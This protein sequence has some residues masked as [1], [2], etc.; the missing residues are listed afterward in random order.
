M[1]KTKVALLTIFFVLVAWLIFYQFFKSCCGVP[2]V[3][4]Q[5]N[6]FSDEDA[7]LPS[8]CFSQP[9]LA[10]PYGRNPDF[11]MTTLPETS[12]FD[13]K[14]AS[15]TEKPGVRPDLKLTEQRIF[16]I[17]LE[18]PKL[19][20]TQESCV[21]DAGDIYTSDL[22]ASLQPKRLIY[23][24]I[25]DTARDGGNSCDFS[26]FPHECVMDMTAVNGPVDRIIK[27]AF[28]DGTYAEK[29]ISIPFAGKMADPVIVTPKAAP[30]NGDKFALQFKDTG[31]NTYQ[32]HIAICVPYGNHGVN[33]CL[34][35]WRIDLTRTNDGQMQTDADPV[36]PGLSAKIQKGLVVVQSAMPFVY[37]SDE[38]KINYSVTADKNGTT[39]DGI[40]TTI[41]T[42]YGTSYSLTK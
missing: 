2:P 26:G 11:F 36:I 20:L 12:N 32:V 41:E 40:K 7:R 29:K 13:I 19:K 1:K 4:P 14:I 9:K 35:G 27:V 33:P 31:A 10:D 21:S 23:S 30:K 22:T 18:R 16:S 17:F 5:E 15:V 24:D 34:N 42:N 38:N 37:Q 8:Y 28:E 25:T 39:P 6:R 3:N